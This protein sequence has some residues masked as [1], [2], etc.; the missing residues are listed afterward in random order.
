VKSLE[1]EETET[2]EQI[3]AE[4]TGTAA[5]EASS[6]AFDYILRHASG[7]KLTEQGDFCLSGDEQELRIPNTRRR[8][9]GV[10]EK[11]AG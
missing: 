1:A 4:E 6:E 3:L 8:A 7:K 11:R 2:T 10:V 9:L 5:S